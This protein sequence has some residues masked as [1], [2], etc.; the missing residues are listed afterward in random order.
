V[1]NSNL[2]IHAL[3]NY[4]PPL[5]KLI[6]AWKYNS[7]REIGTFLAQ[8]CWW[9][10]VL[11]QC[12]AISFV[13]LHPVKKQERGFNQAQDLALELAKLHQLPVVDW[14]DR[15]THAKS[16]AT[17]PSKRARRQ[18]ILGQFELKR[19]LKNDLSAFK[20][21]TKG[22]TLLILDDVTTTGATLL[23]VAN[24][25]KTLEWGQVLG[26]TVAYRN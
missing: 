3:A 13:P 9:S 26:L 4:Q 6:H 16:Q 20:N 5:S 2:E 14:V 18:N 7:V 10:A 22:K 17:V 11:P 23:E 1:P 19:G 15:V 24:Q 8:L 25:Y 21:Q 12:D